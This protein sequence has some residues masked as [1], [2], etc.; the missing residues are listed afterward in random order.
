LFVDEIENNEL[1]GWMDG[2]MA[3]TRNKSQSEIISPPQKTATQ[4][5][6]I[7]QSDFYYKHNGE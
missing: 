4:K 3:V 5:G 1:E 6:F 7:Y 2:W